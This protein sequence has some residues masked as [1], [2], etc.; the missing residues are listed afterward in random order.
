M[1]YEEYCADYRRAPSEEGEKIFNE[2]RK[3][4]AIELASMFGISPGNGEV[5]RF[6]SSLEKAAD[7]E[8][9]NAELDCTE[10]TCRFG[11]GDHFCSAH[12]AQDCTLNSNRNWR[13]K[14]P[15]AEN[16]ST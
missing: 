4:V 14:K 3:T 12:K 2:A 1:K 13:P 11:I 7:C 9:N 8:V 5:D 15:E 10:R 6:L 16:A